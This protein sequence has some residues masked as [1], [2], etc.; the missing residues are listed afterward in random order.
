MNEWVYV[1]GGMAAASRCRIAEVNVRSC[2]HGMLSD[3][4]IHQ[5]TAFLNDGKPGEW[6]SCSSFRYGSAAGM[7]VLTL[8]IN[9]GASA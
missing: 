8:E 7:P 1:G 5:A 6:A 2:G 3:F 4:E 9:E